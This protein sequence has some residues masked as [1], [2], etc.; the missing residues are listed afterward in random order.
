MLRARVTFHNTTYANRDFEIR[1]KAMRGAPDRGWAEQIRKKTAICHRSNSR[2]KS[3]TRPSS[4]YVKRRASTI[5]VARSTRS[6]RTH[7]AAQEWSGRARPNARG[8]ARTD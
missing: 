5:R 7:Q 3:L 1:A 6:G 8:D 4:K 2:E